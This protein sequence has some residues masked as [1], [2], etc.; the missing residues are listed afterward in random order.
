MTTSQL[1]TN[2]RYRVL[3]T[4][5]GA[6]YSA[7]NDC[8]LTRWSGD[9]TRDADGFFCYLRDLESG[10]Y[11]SA[12][13]HPVPSTPDQYRVASG[14]N[15]VRIVRQD[16]GIEVQTDI[17]VAL[18]ADVEWRRY[19]ISNLSPRPRV[20][21]LTT[22][23]EVV[24]NIAGV[25]AGHPAFS[26]LFVQTEGLPAV[27]GVLAHRRPRSPEEAQRVM[28]HA[29]FVVGATQLGAPEVETDR[30]RFLGRGRTLANPVVLS[31]SAP[32]SGTVGNVLDP[33]LSLRRVVT[34]EPGDT[35]RLDAVLG[36]G[37]DRTAVEAALAAATLAGAGDA[38][39]GGR[40]TVGSLVHP[41]AP[42]PSR[43][44]PAP[45]VGASA[46]V[47]DVE[48]DVPVPICPDTLSVHT[49]DA[50]VSV[51]SSGSVPVPAKL[52]D[53]PCA[54]EA[55]FAGDVITATGGWLNGGGALASAETSDCDTV[56][57]ALA[58][59]EIAFACVEPQKYSTALSLTLLGVDT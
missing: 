10:R 6:G 27:A 57:D 34:L 32:L 2:G 20:L 43:Y 29:L 50:P 53:A 11:W 48:N 3:V 44:Q 12:G 58:A 39:F 47:A 33:I 45:G 7:L 26:K 46:S 9:S 21:E 4:A 24:L 15:L 14:P 13:F 28:G 56:R 22:C 41:I 49:S 51:P 18:D 8:E 38:V 30:M 36:A 19:T 35:V 23:A 42:A 55:L 40:E 54:N 25:D 16:D 17:A 52:T 59:S 5:A 37:M 1:L 31:G